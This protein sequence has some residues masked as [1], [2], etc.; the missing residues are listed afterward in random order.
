[1]REIN[2]GIDDGVEE[3]QCEQGS[4]D[5][6]PATRFSDCY[7]ETTRGEGN[8]AHHKHCNCLQSKLQKAKLKEED[9]KEEK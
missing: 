6:F 1:M 9:V 3:G 8:P 7:V 5:I 4:F 2:E